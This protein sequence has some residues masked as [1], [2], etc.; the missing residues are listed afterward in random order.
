MP[1]P[2]RN[3]A[4]SSHRAPIP[5]RACP[6]PSPDPQWLAIVKLYGEEPS[7]IFLEAEACLAD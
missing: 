5:A 2:G 3:L 7:D 1:A 4:L 6:A